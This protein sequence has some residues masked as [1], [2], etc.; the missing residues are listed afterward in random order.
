[1]AARQGLEPGVHV[2]LVLPAAVAAE[3]RV[4]PARGYFSFPTPP[5]QLVYVQIQG[6]NVLVHEDV[7]VQG[8]VALAQEAGVEEVAGA[9]VPGEEEPGSR[10]H[11]SRLHHTLGRPVYSG[12]SREHLFTR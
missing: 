11:V 10:P 6:W 2:H 12:S 8:D 9:R 3:R 7:A 4:A 5:T 1:M